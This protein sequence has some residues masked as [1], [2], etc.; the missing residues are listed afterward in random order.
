M[1][2]T[3]IYAAAAVASVAIVVGGVLRAL[4]NWPR[5]APLHVSPSEPVTTAIAVLASKVESLERVVS[6]LDSKVTA[7][8]MSS[9]HQIYFT[10]SKEMD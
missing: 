5:S 7:V 4:S 8:I 10:H 9:G 2:E 6:D 3:L 1:T